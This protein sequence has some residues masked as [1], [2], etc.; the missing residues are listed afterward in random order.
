MPS[1]AVRA[2]APA[3]RALRAHPS[4]PVVGVA[5][6]VLCVSAVAVTWYA[7]IALEAAL[8]AGDTSTATRVVP[9]A[10]AALLGVAVL[11]A[12]G[13]SVAAAASFSRRLRRAIDPI[14]SV[15]T[16]RAGGETAARVVAA[17]DEWVR[18]LGG[19]LNETL[20]AVDAAAAEARQV[21][22][23]ALLTAGGQQRA[24]LDAADE[25][26]IV[27]TDVDG[28]I[29]VFNRGAERVFGYRAAEMVDRQTPVGLH[30]ATEVEQ[31][32]RE[33]SWQ[34]ERDIAGFD[35]FSERV[36]REGRERR[37]WTCIRKDGTAITVDLVVTAVHGPAGEIVGYLGVAT[38]ITE[39][40]RTERELDQARERA[41]EASRAKS[42]F[43][44]VMSHEI[45]TPMNGVLGMTSLLLET[46][47]TPEQRDYV[48][49]LHQSGESLLRIINDILDFSKVES[50]RMTI[51]SVDFDLRPAI[52]DAVGLVAP[53]AQQK[54]VVVEV[55]IDPTIP[56]RVVG[57]PG[58]IRQVLLNL[59]S[60]AI[61]F[62]ERGSVRVA[63]TAA[64]APGD[65]KLRV[66]VE[67]TGIGI[68]PTRIGS[69]FEPFEQADASTTRRFGGTGLGLAISQRL[70]TAMGGDIGVE[71]APGRGSTFWFR[72][73]LR[74][75]SPSAGDGSEGRPVE[76]L[77]LSDAADDV[78]P[79]FAP[80]PAASVLV[81]EA[82]P[83]GQHL[84]RRL[85][86][87]LGCV[88]DT[89]ADGAEA[90]A[91]ASRGHY[92]LILVDDDLPAVDG[93][94]VIERLRACHA[95]ASAWIVGLVA[96][97]RA[98]GER[99]VGAEPDAYLVRP[100]TADRLSAVL[101]RLQVA[102]RS[103]A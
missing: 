2:T 50:G 26:G 68:D 71:S 10:L 6:A 54:G 1:N 8:A 52:R 73:P 17:D 3:V 79:A 58:R 34:F 30:L 55:D 85:L 49:A 97:A 78:S 53:R 63:V 33:L 14:A 81:A 39:R 94:G 80:G 37:D 62:T 28:L 7:E 29:R 66:A 89:T 95:A 56:E 87:R 42:E 102:G 19:L 35:V 32:G 38:D 46:A 16:R 82:N 41:E 70:V 90:V 76:P 44:A 23:Q 83:I 20:D 59:V 51:E 4:W 57:D 88:V 31:R 9:R 18:G 15:L 67:D 84:A 75:A 25:V 86:G 96:D 69:I 40:R 21:A 27:F 36:R 93:M 91:L 5:G 22:D 100:V 101:E 13:V 103:V 61:K 43:L 60:N 12:V 24:L 11:L 45:R 47:L 98:E 48:N 74:V 99:R 77:V 72:L 92:D 64:P 65:R